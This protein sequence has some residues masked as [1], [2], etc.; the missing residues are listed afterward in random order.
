MT[1]VVTENEN[2]ICTV[3]KEYFDKD[4]VEV[5]YCIKNKKYDVVE[6]RVDSLSQAH[7]FMNAMTQ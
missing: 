4:G 7:I 6:A 3:D 5:G 2:Y 1:I